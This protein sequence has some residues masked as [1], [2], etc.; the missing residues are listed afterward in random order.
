MAKDWQAVA[1]TINTRM[2]ELPMSQVELANRA[3][4]AVATLRQIQHAVPKDR[5]PRTLAAIS[6]ALGLRANH[7][8]EVADGV[9]SASGP[10]RL[11]RLESELADLRE[12]VVEL[13]RQITPRPAG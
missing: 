6:E 3:R 1:K 10:D 12:R 5:N 11:T 13:E 4:V 2:E 7:L 9:A 8:E